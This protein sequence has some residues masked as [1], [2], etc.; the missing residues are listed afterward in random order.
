VAP[1][2]RQTDAGKLTGGTILEHE[3]RGGIV[4]GFQAESAESAESAGDEPAG[5]TILA[6]LSVLGSAPN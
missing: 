2:V 5:G 6:T 4:S 3:K 1:N